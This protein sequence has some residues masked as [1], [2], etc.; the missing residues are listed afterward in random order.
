MLD[1]LHDPVLRQVQVLAVGTVCAEH[2]GYVRVFGRLGFSFDVLGSDFGFL[3][4]EHGEQGPLDDREPLRIVFA[5]DRA[6]RLFG[7]HFR[8]NDV[9]VRFGQLAALCVE[10]RLVGS[11]HV[12]TA[13]FQRLCA[14]IGGVESD[15]G[16]FQVIGAEVVGD[17]QLGGGTGLDTDSCTVQFLGT[18][19]A[20]LFVYQKADAVVV[21]HA[22]KHQ[23]HGRIAGAGPGGVTRKDVDLTR[24]QCS[25][26][27]FGVQLAELDLGGV[28]KYCGG[29]CAA[30][31]SIDTG[32]L[33]G[34]VWNG[35]PWQAIADAALN[36]PFL[37]DSVKGGAC[38][39]S[40]GH[41]KCSQG[42]DDSQGGFQHLHSKPPVCSLLCR[43]FSRVAPL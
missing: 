39:G 33:A 5:H 2:T 9:V 28:A 3:G 26:T 38:V 19:D 31:V 12:A 6:Q 17:V 42:G 29:D 16:V 8:Q 34:G 22:G 24:L 23:A 36:K 18:V 4:V 13:A 35:K 37:H 20:Q 40:P 10:L 43:R 7:D 21:S 32:D 25:E 1:D 30:D 27:L 15:R 11:Q 14:F 41:T